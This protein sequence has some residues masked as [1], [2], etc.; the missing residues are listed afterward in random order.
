[1][2]DLP[3]L[4]TIRLDWVDEEEMA[5]PYE[6][7]DVVLQTG[8]VI[9]IPFLLK[10]SLSGENL[11]EHPQVLHRTERIFLKPHGDQ[12]EKGIRVSARLED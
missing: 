11:T 5:W 1:M 6:A 12:V 4:K 8:Q 3:E 9:W 2:A 7:E 10:G